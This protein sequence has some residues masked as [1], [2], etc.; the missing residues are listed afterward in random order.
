MGSLAVDFL[1]ARTTG[2]YSDRQD[3]W[4]SRMGMP[5]KDQISD[6]TVEKFSARE[7]SYI[8]GSVP[9]GFIPAFIIIGFDVQSNR[10][11]YVVRACD[12]TGRTYLVDHG[13]APSWGDLEKIQDDYHGIWP[14]AHSYII[15]DIN[16]EDRRAEALEQIYLRS[17]RGWY[18][19]E[20]FDQAKELVR[21]EQA[22]V[23]LGGK[24]QA[25][26]HCIRKLVISAYEFKVELEKRF[27]GDI[28]NWFVYQLPLAATEAEI[29]ERREY[30]KQLL[31]ERRVPR[32]RRVAGKPPFEW[33]SRTGNNHYF[34]CEVYI[35]AL[36]WV[37]LKSRSTA[38]KSGHDQ[39]SQTSRRIVEV[40]R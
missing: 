39:A 24:L 8:R 33:R 1:S 28:P 20:A 27:S 21:L 26:G 29:A 13:D 11:P 9:D 3:F 4:N 2:F 16:Y 10:L 15:G 19:A 36:Y 12:L 25:H 31:D 14:S 32:K 18:G 17:G 23:Y 34:D 5:W 38:A 35:M 6:V 30:Y 40:T 22:N 7:A 37:L